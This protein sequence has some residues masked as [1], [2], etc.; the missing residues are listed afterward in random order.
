MPGETEFFILLQRYVLLQSNHCPGAFKGREIDT[1]EEFPVEH[2][3]QN[4]QKVRGLHVEFARKRT[5][6]TTA[7]QT[8]DAPNLVNDYYL[9]LLDWSVANMVSL[10]L[11]SSVYLWNPRDSS[12]FQLND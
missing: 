6:S 1:P 5:I 3:V 2:S 9:N 8:L 7:A 10:G 11:G 4:A 12:T